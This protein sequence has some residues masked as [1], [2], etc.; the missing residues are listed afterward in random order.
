MLNIIFLTFVG[1]N[2]GI[3]QDNLT[4][5]MYLL[6]GFVSI[7]AVQEACMPFNTLH[8]FLFTTTAIG[9]YVAAFLF[10][11]ILKLTMPT[12]NQFIVIVVLAVISYL[13]IFIKRIIYKKMLKI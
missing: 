3:P 6:I 1:T 10:N 8:V 7:L 4:T 9:F 13:I 12:A 11:N 5:M 2:M